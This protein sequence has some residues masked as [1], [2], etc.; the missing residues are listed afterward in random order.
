MEGRRCQS[1][2][3]E[4][5]QKETKLLWQPLDSHIRKHFPLLVEMPGFIGPYMC[6]K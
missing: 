3:L 1:L 2:C 4:D 6:L 5:C